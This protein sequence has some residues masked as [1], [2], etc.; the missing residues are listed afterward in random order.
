[1]EE[2]KEDLSGDE[3]V[4]GGMVNKETVEVADL[5]RTSDIMQIC[6][7][8]IEVGWIEKEVIEEREDGIWGG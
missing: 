8:E 3:I 5:V 4:D 1:M 2:A 7:R 6:G